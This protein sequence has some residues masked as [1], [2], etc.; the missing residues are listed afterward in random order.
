MRRRGIAALALASLF[1]VGCGQAVTN[2][3]P[4]DGNGQGSALHAHPQAVEPVAGAGGSSASYPA[5]AASAASVGVGS[6]SD[7]AV[8]PQPV[9]DAEIRQ[10]LAASGLSASTNQAQLTSNG[11]AIAPVDAP[12]AVQEV[13][14]A[15]NEIARLPYR[16]GG[17]HITYEDTA[18]DCSGSI[19]FVFAAAHLL[20]TMVVSGQLENWGDPGP[21][22]WITVFANAGH[23]FMYVAGLRFDTVALAETGSRWS[24]RPADE[25]DLSTFAVRHP[26]GL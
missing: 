17:G 6:G 22:K 4:S 12:A 15:G 1:A 26:P 5:S 14:S 3:T 2:T 25:P 8:L 24:N 11:L 7:S 21:G 16:Y 19:S 23:T 18:Y 20:N 10:E 9:S 13:I